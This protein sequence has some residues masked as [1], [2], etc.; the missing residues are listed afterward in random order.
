MRDT[1][2][3]IAS[4]IAGVGGVGI[5]RI[6]GP[7]ALE[8][9]QRGFHSSQKTWES[10]RVL[11][12]HVQDADGQILDDGLAWYM[13]APKT[14][15]GED[16]V[17]LS[18]HGN[19]L[20]LSKVVERFVEHGARLARPGEFSQR[21]YLEGKIDL[22]QA[23]AIAQLIASGSQEEARLAHRRLEGKTSTYIQ[24]LLESTTTL[25]AQLEADVDFPEE[26]LDLDA[27]SHLQDKA[28]ELVEK[29]QNLLRSYSHIQK[30]SSGF[31]VLL[32]GLP[33]A[34]KS[35]FF[36]ALLGSDRAIVTSIAGTTRDTLEDEIHI[37]GHTVRIIDSAGY[38]PGTIDPI[39]REGVQRMEKKLSQVDLV[40]WLCDVQDPQFEEAKRLFESIE[41]SKRWWIWSKTDQDHNDLPNPPMELADV[42]QVSAVQGKGM[43]LFQSKLSKTFEKNID[44]SMSTGGISNDRQRKLLQDFV[45]SMMA[46]QHALAQNLSPELIAFELRQGYRALQE[47]LGKDQDMED[48][49][50]KVFSQFCIGK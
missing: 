6:S 16:V 21:A 42:L 44:D 3:A 25:L 8:I 26:E 37:Q 12:G 40:C 13:K 49:Y 48:V 50:D 35:T 5:I 38:A 39:E 27:R 33:N 41:P 11:Y 9:A 20:L 2:V 4:S 15:T 36:N 14:F 46:T 7:K 23:E 34:G 10:H 29:A 47:L 28:F 22:M 17:E 32:A 24:E 18:L 19:P 45:Q 30:L 43:E 31:H 1:I